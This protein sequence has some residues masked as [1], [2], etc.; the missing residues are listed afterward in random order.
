MAISMSGAT[1]DTSERDRLLQSSVD[2]SAVAGG[3]GFN[4][5]RTGFLGLGGVEASGV[6]LAGITESFASNVCTAIDN[7]KT[8]VQ[9]E[10]DKLQ[11]VES[12]EAFKGTA[13]SAALEKFVTAVRDVGT[14]YLER[15]SGA[16]T[17]IVNS[18]A[19]AY[20]T[21]DT[22]LSG[23]LNSDSSSIGING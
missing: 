8:A 21:Q 20:Q 16:E 15:L 10:L 11:A 19:Q 2:G 9:T 13:V 1:V 12:N 7:Y 14:Q 4:V 18:V 22:D 23:N 3:E 17:Q 6:T 5:Q